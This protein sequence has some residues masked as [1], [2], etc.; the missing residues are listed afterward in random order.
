[1]D[2]STLSLLALF[3]IAAV[4]LAP[5]EVTLIGMG[6]VAAAKDGPIAPTILVASAGCLLCDYLLYVTG[7]RGGSRALARVRRRRSADTTIRWL[8]AR[9][10]RRPVAVLVIAR[11]LPAGGTAGSLL[12]GSLRWPR[13]AFLTASVIG[14]IL[15][16]TYA[17]LLGYLGGSM[18]DE[19]LMS[20]LL[21]LAV[22][23]VLTAL[24]AAV[25]RRRTG[26][27]LDYAR[28]TSGGT[29]VHPAEQA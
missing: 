18:V 19:S 11:W 6:V 14:V 10:E 2:V 7:R 22:A 28:G 24:V 3:V 13:A 27:H 17:V 25:W 15:W 21:S 20:L 5:T 23:A 9:L 26:H 12:A 8:T 16:S 1:M 4:P 29:A